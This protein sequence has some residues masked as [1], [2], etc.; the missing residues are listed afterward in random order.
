MT[1]H[2]HRAAADIAQQAA[3]IC[4]PVD[5]TRT[6]PRCGQRGRCIGNAN[7][8]RHQILHTACGHAWNGRVRALDI[9]E[10]VEP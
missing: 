6:C 5:I 9:A 4:A 3:D 7:G 2:L 1:A 8:V 10:E